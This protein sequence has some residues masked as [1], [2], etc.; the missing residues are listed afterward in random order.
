MVH[1]WPCPKMLDIS[2][3]AWPSAVLSQVRAGRARGFRESQPTHLPLKWPPR[4]AA[5]GAHP[6]LLTG[7]LMV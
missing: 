7:F 1:A 4:D 6:F 2:G 5:L 3:K